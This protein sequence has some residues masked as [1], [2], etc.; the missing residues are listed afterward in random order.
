MYG[1]QRA[2]GTYRH[3]CVRASG[4]G[5]RTLRV[6]VEGARRPRRRGGF[7]RSLP[8]LW[9]LCSPRLLGN[10]F[11]CCSSIPGWGQVLR[12][13]AAAQHI[14]HTY[15]HT[16]RLLGNSSPGHTTRAPPSKCNRRQGRVRTQFYANWAPTSLASRCRDPWRSPVRAF[17]GSRKARLCQLLFTAGGPRCGGGPGPPGPGWPPTHVGAGGAGPRPGK[18]AVPRAAGS[19][20]SADI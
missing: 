18:G 12:V 5:C 9:S 2:P 4:L 15:T 14:I 1:T 20:P 16:P 11:R 7:L 17:A 6:C 8:S 3:A 19:D 13:L 10:S